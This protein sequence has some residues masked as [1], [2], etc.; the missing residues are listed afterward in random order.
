MTTKKT[1]R[2]LRTDDYNQSK[3]PDHY[4]QHTSP[5]HRLMWSILERAVADAIGN[6]GATSTSSRTMQEAYCWIMYPRW[7]RDYF[8]HSFEGICQELE[9]NPLII[10]KF[11]TIQCR[12]PQIERVR[13]KKRGNI[14]NFYKLTI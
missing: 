7:L 5:E 4:H 2:L 6:T 9:I 13:R 12:K 8:T 11:I 3:T 10:R 14:Q 1:A